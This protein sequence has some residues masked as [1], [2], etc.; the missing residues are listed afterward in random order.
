MRTPRPRSGAQQLSLTLHA[1]K[2]LAIGPT[3]RSRALT[4]LA[5][6]LLEATG[7]AMQERGDERD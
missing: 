6:L 7:A 1:A 2:P 5:R 3:E 4:L